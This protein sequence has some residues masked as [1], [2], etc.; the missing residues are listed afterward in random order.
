MSET[1]TSGKVAGTDSL[2]VCSTVS[3]LD[4]QGV[5]CNSEASTNTLHG[6]GARLVELER[7]RERVAVNRFGAAAAP[8]P[9][10]SWPRW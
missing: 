3:Q 8:A 1:V 4:M 5:P 2:S 10:C 9:S 6:A 7:D